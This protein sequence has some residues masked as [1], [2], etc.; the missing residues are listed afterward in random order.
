M[1]AF[2]DNNFHVGN[3]FQE[4][5][6][7]RIRVNFAQKIHRLS[8]GG[9]AYGGGGGFGGA[10]GGGGDDYGGVGVNTRDKILRRLHNAGDEE[11]N[12]NDELD[13]DI[14]EGGET[15]EDI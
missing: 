14:S 11:T 1:I 3:K 2:R 10:G 7:R 6:G 15:W 8:F 4:L 13:K 5:H 12:A 9:G